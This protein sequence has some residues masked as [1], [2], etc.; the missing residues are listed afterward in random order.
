MSFIKPI[1]GKLFSTIYSLYINTEPKIDQS[2]QNLSAEKTLVFKPWRR[3][4]A[5][6]L[7]L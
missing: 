6:P 2:V 1:W 3:E 5:S 7:S 4:A